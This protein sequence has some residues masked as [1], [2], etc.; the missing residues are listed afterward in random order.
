[1]APR[2]IRLKNLSV[3]INAETPEQTQQYCNILLNEI[4]K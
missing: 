4:N 1:M 2:L 3:F